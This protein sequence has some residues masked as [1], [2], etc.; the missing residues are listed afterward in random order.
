MSC[1]ERKHEPQGVLVN[2][3]QQVLTGKMLKEV[4]LMETMKEGMI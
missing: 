2:E 3:K 4:G 1:R